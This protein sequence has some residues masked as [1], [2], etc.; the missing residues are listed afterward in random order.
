M[1]IN[2]NNN[3]MATDPLVTNSFKKEDFF[4]ALCNFLVKRGNF[5]YRILAIFS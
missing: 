3:N 2:E 1:A 5:L 4:I